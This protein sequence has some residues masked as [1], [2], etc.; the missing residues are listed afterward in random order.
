MALSLISEDSSALTRTLRM[1]RLLKKEARNMRIGRS[2]LMQRGPVNPPDAMHDGRSE[3]LACLQRALDNAGQGIPHLALAHVEDCRDYLR[4]LI[5][6]LQ[7]AELRYSQSIESLNMILAQAL[8]RR[9]S[10]RGESPLN[11][12]CWTATGI[13]RA[14]FQLHPNG[15]LVMDAQFRI[16]TINPVMRRILDLSPDESVDGL[17][18]STLL[19]VPALHDAA[20]EVLASGVPHQGINMMDEDGADIVSNTSS[21]FRASTIVT[22]R[23]CCWWRMILRVYWKLKLRCQTAKSVSGSLFIRLRSDWCILTPAVAFCA[24]TENFNKYWVTTQPRCRPCI[25]A[26]WPTRRKSVIT[27]R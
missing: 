25:Y 16:R 6:T 19:K 7:K 14:Y 17:A 13:M 22:S 24:V 18:L 15:L 21:A 9:H 1:R 27:T 2:L 26:I 10:Y 8:R 11:G 3:T 20:K 4:A 12:S 23:Y 5:P